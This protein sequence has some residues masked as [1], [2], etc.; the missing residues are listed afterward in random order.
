M[1]A[2]GRRELAPDPRRRPRGAGDPRGEHDPDA[3]DD[4]VDADIPQQTRLDRPD[5][6]DRALVLG[7]VRQR[8]DQVVAGVAPDD[9]HDQTHDQQADAATHQQP[10]TPAL[11][12]VDGCREQGEHEKEEEVAEHADHLHADGI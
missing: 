12:Q 2:H 1:V 9:E 10:Q 5:P 6:V 11:G 7:V 4:G 8:V 3:V